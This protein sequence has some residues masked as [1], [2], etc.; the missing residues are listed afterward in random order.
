M[1][2]DMPL[3]KETSNMLAITSFLYRLKA[4]SVSR[5]MVVMSSI[6][7]PPPARC[8]LITITTVHQVDCSSQW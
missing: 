1:Q 8:V 2:V 3:N 5:Y 7:A 4:L 6:P